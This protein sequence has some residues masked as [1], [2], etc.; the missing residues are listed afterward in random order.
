MRPGVRAVVCALLLPAALLVNDPA[1]YSPFGPS[2]W[3][4]ITVVGLVAIAA[5]TWRGRVLVARRPMVVWVGLLVWVAAAAAVGVDPVYAWIGTPQRHFGVFAWVLCAGLF[6]AGQRLDDE[7]DARLV[8]AAAVVAG[9]LAGTWAVAE[10][11]GWRP[12]PVA[13]GSRVIGSLGSAAFL[14]SAMVL[15]TPLALGIALDR[16]WV[17]SWRLVAAAAA[18]VSGCAL[19]ASGARAAWGGAIIGGLVAVALHRRRLVARPR[20]TLAVAG[21]VVAAVVGLGAATG[22][23]S[24]VSALFDPHVGGGSSR[25]DEWAVAGRVLLAHPLTGVGPEGYRIAFTRQVDAHYVATYGISPLPDRAHDS[26]LDVAVT[27]GL[28]GVGIYLGLAG[29]VAVFLVRA[30]RRGPPWL[31]GVALLACRLQCRGPGPFPAGRARSRGVVAGRVGGGAQR[32]ARR[33]VRAL[34]SS[35]PLTVS[36]PRAPSVAAVAGTRDVM[37]DGPPTRP[38]HTRRGRRPAAVRQAARA[39]GLRP[40]QIEYR[41]AAARAEAAPDTPDAIDRGLAELA[42]ALDVSPG[43]PGFRRTG[44]PPLERALRSGGPADTRRAERTWRNLVARDPFNVGDQLRLGVAEAQA[45]DR[46]RPRTPGWR[47]AVGAGQS[48][49]A[50]D[51]ATLYASQGRWPARGRGG[52]R[53]LA[54][55]PANQAARGPRG[56]SRHLEPDGRPW[57][58]CRG[59]SHHPRRPTR[60]IDALTAAPGRGP[61]LPGNQPGH[62]APPRPGPSSRPPVGS[63]RPSWTGLAGVRSPTST[64][65]HGTTSPG[66]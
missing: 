66:P 47:R 29:V 13:G 30:A 28:P 41:L 24:R 17:R 60:V 49:A 15:V 12:L 38:W 5:A 48:S 3:A 62:R 6:V 9:G 63:A 61:A 45:G 11:L 7:G 52:A 18:G 50:T 51:L 59:T 57:C 31:V 43:D 56:K 35:A 1:G 36:S 2:K 22:A 26:L 65:R 58:T 42:N 53:A 25:L 32:P 34:G 46:R 44:P 55:D 10:R 54:R 40:D 19:I 4:A 27:T 23:S 16:S 20:R 8:A 33:T 14:G 37:A 64:E 39:A 21:L